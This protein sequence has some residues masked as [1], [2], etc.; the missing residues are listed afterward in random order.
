MV[1]SE[2]EA[3][4]CTAGVCYNQGE[5]LESTLSSI[6]PIVPLNAR[7]LLLFNAC[8]VQQEGAVLV[9]GAA[10][11]VETPAETELASESVFIPTGTSC[12]IELI[13]HEEFEPGRTYRIDI[14]D[15]DGAAVL[16]GAVFFETGHEGDNVA[17]GRAEFL[18]ANYT[19]GGG[20]CPSMAEWRLSVAPD[21]LRPGEY[22]EFHFSLDQSFGTYQRFLRLSGFSEG[23][24]S[25]ADGCD[26]IELPD[27][28]GEVAW[29]RL[30]VVDAAGNEGDWS[31]SVSSEGEPGCASVSP[32]NRG[33]IP[34]V[35]LAALA[36]I[37]I[38][39]DQ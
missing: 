7:P 15:Q 13:P 1:I 16:E 37:G 30:R 29:A 4:T 12:A 17:P 22:L 9:P 32:T 34:E 2:A 19:A 33:L 36:L 26:G 21:I 28:R 14:D 27:R 3:F 18:T 25:F 8:M 20:I 39:R 35:F 11:I 10:V 23:F 24:H 6:S 5:D 38:R 31:E